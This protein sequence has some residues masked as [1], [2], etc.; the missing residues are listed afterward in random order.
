MATRRLCFG[1]N[2]HPTNN[3]T[4]HPTQALK[5]HPGPDNDPGSWFAVTPSPADPRRVQQTRASLADTDTVRWQG[6]GQPGAGALTLVDAAA[7]NA[8]QGCCLV[9]RRPMLRARFLKRKPKI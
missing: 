7:A 2:N 4:Q 9:S 8:L 1:D 6:L 3:Q 5:A